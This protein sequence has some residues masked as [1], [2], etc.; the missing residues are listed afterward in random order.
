MP[1]PAVTRLIAAH[2]RAEAATQMRLA[3]AVRIGMHANG[4]EWARFVVAAGARAAAAGGDRP[5]WDRMHER[6]ERWLQKQAEQAGGD[7]GD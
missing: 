2:A 6:N 3:E 4:E 5:A 1:W 7:V